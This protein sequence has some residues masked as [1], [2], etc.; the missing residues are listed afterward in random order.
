ML[1]KNY[2][3]KAADL[4]FRNT[5]NGLTIEDRTRSEFNDYAIVAHISVGRKIS[6]RYHPIS[7]EQMDAITNEATY[8]DPQVSVNQSDKVFTTRPL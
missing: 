5:G 2:K 7:Q 4:V 8:N 3:G 6:H 1:D